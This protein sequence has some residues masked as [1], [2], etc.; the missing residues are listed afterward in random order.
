M[1]NREKIIVGLMVLS[2]IYGVY[3]LFFESPEKAA[4]F[5]SGGARELEALN[6]FIT[7]VADKTKSGP[8]KEQAYVLNKAQTA[9]KQ[10]PLIQL[11]SKE[12]EVDTGPEPVLDARVQYTGFLQMGE[13][14]LA[15]INGTEYETGDR[16]EPQGFVIRRILPNQVVVSPPGEKK[17]LMILPME[18]TE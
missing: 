2:V 7:K 14:R 11:E 5:D 4:S 6:T 8:S 15:I 13:T 10:D 1:S 9:W 16:L 3:I 17:K 12:V 18:E